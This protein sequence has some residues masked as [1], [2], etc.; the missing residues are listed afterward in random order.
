MGVAP[1]L[2][3][4]IKSGHAIQPAALGAYPDGVV[5]CLCNPAQWGPDG[6]LHRRADNPVVLG[7]DPVRQ[8]PGPPR[9]LIGVLNSLTCSE[10][11]I[12]FDAKGAANVSVLHPRH[13]LAYR[14]RRGGR[15]VVRRP[16]RLAT[17]EGGPPASAGG[18]TPPTG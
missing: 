6:S 5:R 13:A 15:S 16:D 18:A 12:R 11:P 8:G 9:A 10:L 2:L 4:R 3:A 7:V 1:V 14:G 17:G